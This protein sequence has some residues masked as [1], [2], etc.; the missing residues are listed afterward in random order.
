VKDRIRTA[1][2]FNVEPFFRCESHAPPP[3]PLCAAV[4]ASSSSSSSSSCAAYG[5]ASMMAMAAA[6]LAIVK[7]AHAIFTVGC[8]G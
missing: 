2:C 7:L 8:A 1:F 6:S 3:L 5:M 4:A